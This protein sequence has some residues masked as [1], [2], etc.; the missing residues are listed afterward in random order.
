MKRLTTIMI[1]VS[2]IFLTT[3]A[4]AEN[5][6]EMLSGGY[7]G[8]EILVFSEISIGP[9]GNSIIMFVVFGVEITPEVSLEVGD[10]LFENTKVTKIAFEPGIKFFGWFDLPQEGLRTIWINNNKIVWEAIE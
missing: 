9:D 8:N 6:K 4:L 10:E 5:S 3:T 1:M 2:M 7:P